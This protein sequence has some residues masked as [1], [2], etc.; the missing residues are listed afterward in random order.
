MSTPVWTFI[1]DV[2]E[3]HI[4]ELGFL[5]GQR[6]S[7]LRSYQV[8]APRFRD[9]EE[10]I[11]GRIDGIR[12]VGRD[13]R[14]LLEAKLAADD[15]LDVFAGAYGLLDPA[16][17][18]DPAEI[19]AIAEKAEGPRL[20]GLT[21]ALSHSPVDV[22]AHV[23]ELQ[24]AGNPAVAAAAMEVLAFRGALARESAAV[25]PILLNDD[26]KIKSAGWRVVSLALV[27]VRAEL[28]AAAL[29]DEDAALRAAALEAA[30]WCGIK[31]VLTLVRQL[32]SKSPVESIEALELL[33][34]LAGPEDVPLMKQIA[35]TA[36]LGAARYRIL[37]SFGHPDLIDHLFR[38]MEHEDPKIAFAAG[39]AFTK[40]TAANID[41]QSVVEVPPADAA[42]DDPLAAEFA[43]QVT[44][45][46][47]AAARREWQRL[48]PATTSASRLAGA[49]DVSR[50]LD[51]AT[52]G[53][54][55]MQTRYECCLRSRF[56]N[57][58]TGSLVHLE[59]FPN[60]L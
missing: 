11:L 22:R 16:G 4:D 41:S 36:E 58:W 32:A 55:D 56:Y 31:G 54:L 48:G 12:A 25:E 10:R 3:E 30:G 8:S 37:G 51:A 45:P 7:A 1:P 27:P 53:A 6:L 44:R 47:P 9:L 33:A 40:M 21:M 29:R 24:K 50:A 60:K 34:V 38:G 19:I 26:P 43:D 14:P 35:Q 46:D 52:F 39:A 59:A 15:A 49:I 57:A 20:K 28:F 42:P 13:A 2:L 5:W 17:H 18:S 23:I